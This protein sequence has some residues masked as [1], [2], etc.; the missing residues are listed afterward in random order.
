MAT[1]GFIE[2][3]DASSEVR[4]VYDDIMITRGTDRINNFWKALAVDPEMLRRTWEGVKTV[5]A[6]GAVDQLTKEMIYIAVSATNGCSYCVHSHTASARLKGLTNEM[7]SE[8]I[9]VVGMAN[10]TNALADGFQIEIDQIFKSS[11]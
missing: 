5:M 3:E 9:A 7:L 1:S 10:Q 2:Y 4:K 11:G 6:P 8:L